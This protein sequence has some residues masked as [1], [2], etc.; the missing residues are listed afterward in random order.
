VEQ[1]CEQ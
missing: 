1:F